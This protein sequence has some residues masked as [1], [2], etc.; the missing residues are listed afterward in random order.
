MAF[1]ECIYRLYELTKSKDEEI[2]QLFHQLAF[3]VSKNGI[4]GLV[5]IEDGGITDGVSFNEIL[6]TLQRAIELS[7]TSIDQQ[8]I[9]SLYND[10][11]SEGVDGYKP[12]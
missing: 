12:S 11:L 4:S 10:L 8:R 9:E 6:S 7:A 2:S 3:Y 1:D 5:P